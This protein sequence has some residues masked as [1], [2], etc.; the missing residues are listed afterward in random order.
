MWNRSQV[1]CSAPCSPC[2]IQTC[3]LFQHVQNETRQNL[4]N[5]LHG[6]FVTKQKQP[7][8]FDTVWVRSWRCS[9]LITWFCNHLIAK[10]GDKTAAHSWPD[11]NHLYHAH[12]STSF[13]R[14]RSSISSNTVS[15]MI[16]DLRRHKQP[17][18]QQ[19]WYWPWC[20]QQYCWIKFGRMMKIKILVRQLPK[21]CPTCKDIRC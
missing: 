14:N 17:G 15:I 20:T 6:T 10:S 16:V 19:A 13:S 2:D 12:W 21:V 9:C 18:H 7:L 4:I 1:S 8:S 5:S 11:P 3:I